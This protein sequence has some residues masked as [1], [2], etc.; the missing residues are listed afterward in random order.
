MNRRM[1]AS[2]ITAFMPFTCTSVQF[3]H[4]VVADPSGPHGPQH[5][6]PPCPSPTPKVYSDSSPWSR[7]RDPS[8][9]SSVV[10]LA[11]RVQSFPA[12]GCFPRSQLFASDGQSVGVSAPIQH[13]GETQALGWSTI[14]YQ[15][16]REKYQ[17][18]QIWRWHHSF[19]RKQ[20]GT[21]EPLD[22]RKLA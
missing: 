14:W 22:E 9:S 3:S 4:S 6:R 1:Q 13:W 10:S 8:I 20:R 11:S 7:W 2:G 21:K 12:S 5:T 15:D 17:Q 16:C 19:G 18:P